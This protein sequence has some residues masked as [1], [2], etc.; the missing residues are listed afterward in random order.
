MTPLDLANARIHRLEAEV[1]SLKADI[2]FYRRQAEIERADEASIILSARLDLSPQEAW[3]LSALRGAG[4]RGLQNAF[5]L[6]N[7]PG[8]GKGAE[9]DPTL[10]RTTVCTIRRRIGAD[11]IKTL[12]A[13][14]YAITAKGE[15]L[16]GR[17]LAGHLDDVPEPR[18]MVGRMERRRLSPEAVRVMRG[19]D[20]PDAVRALAAAYGCS[21]GL[22][23]GVRSGELYADVGP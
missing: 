7:M 21:T 1:E 12:T 8:F 4:A 22:V 10:V 20:Q 5:S 15:E 19:A 17:V 14:G 18:A 13:R 16:V 11:T 2:V 6:A 23:Y 9:R 3:L